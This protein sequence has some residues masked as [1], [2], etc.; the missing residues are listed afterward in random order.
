LNVLHDSHMFVLSHCLSQQ[1]TCYDLHPNSSF[2]V[3][4]TPLPLGYRRPIIHLYVLCLDFTADNHQVLTADL[5]HKQI[6]IF[7][8]LSLSEW[9]AFFVCKHRNLLHP[10]RVPGTIVRYYPRPAAPLPMITPTAQPTSLFVHCINI[11]RGCRSRTCRPI[12]L[13]DVKDPTLSRQS[14][15]S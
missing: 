8:S 6:S 12:G 14:A 15:H 10:A 9:R 1:E 5:Y 3:P 7:L 11:E 4:V 2:S 13:W